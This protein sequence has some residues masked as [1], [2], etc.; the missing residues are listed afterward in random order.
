M[1]KASNIQI[2]ESQSECIAIIKL[3]HERCDCAILPYNKSIVATTEVVTATVSSTTKAW[4]KRSPFRFAFPSDPYDLGMLNVAEKA[5]V[6]TR[7]E[8]I[9]RYFD[10]VAC[11]FMMS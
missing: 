8:T 1:K 3:G 6:A 2:S 5:I 4:Y 9:A 11:H 10:V 7:V